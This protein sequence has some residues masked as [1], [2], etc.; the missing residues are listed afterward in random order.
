MDYYIE[1]NGGSNRVVRNVLGPME[2]LVKLNDTIHFEIM[3]VQGIVSTDII[4]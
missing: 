1:F 3:N 4:E 2:A